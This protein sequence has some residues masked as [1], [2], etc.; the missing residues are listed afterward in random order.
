[1]KRGILYDEEVGYSI[2]LALFVFI[3]KIMDKIFNEKEHIQ[4]SIIAI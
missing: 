4:K 3:W 2:N 1:V